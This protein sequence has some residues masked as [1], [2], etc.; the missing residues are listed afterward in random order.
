MPFR[1]TLVDFAPT[2]GT[3]LWSGSWTIIVTR[4]F[5]SNIDNGV[6][7]RINCDLNANDF[8]L[9]EYQILDRFFSKVRCDL[10]ICCPV[11]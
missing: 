3:K 7:V 1:K 11:K 10:V 2:G 4:K 9:Q 8:S 6:T 5:F